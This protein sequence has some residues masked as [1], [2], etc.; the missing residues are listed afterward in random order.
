MNYE[1]LELFK[2]QPSSDRLICSLEAV[3]FIVKA[4]FEL[5]TEAFS[6]CV[7]AL[8]TTPQMVRQQI[9]QLQA[10]AHPRFQR[11]C[12]LRASP[13]LILTTYMTR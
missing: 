12:C 9:S 4:S 13:V 8:Q 5:T 1:P 11:V 3:A 6:Q 7:S 10:G 2:G